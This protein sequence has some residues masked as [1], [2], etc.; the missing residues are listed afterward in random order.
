[1]LAL[2]EA[3]EDFLVTLGEEVDFEVSNFYGL[4]IFNG[5]WLIENLVQVDD[6]VLKLVQDGI[7][8]MDTEELSVETNLRCLTISEFACLLP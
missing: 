4:I 1:M 6:A 3:C 8:Q 5:L 7:V 2:D